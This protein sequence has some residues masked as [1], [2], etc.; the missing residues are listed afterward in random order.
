M[1]NKRTFENYKQHGIILQQPY[2]EAQ[3]KCDIQCPLG[4]NL[5]SFKCESN[6]IA[7]KRAKNFIDART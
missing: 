7:L 5:K 1:A 3:V 4:K 6:I 2:P